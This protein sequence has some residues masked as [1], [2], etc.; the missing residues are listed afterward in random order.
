MEN[1]SIQASEIED[2]LQSYPSSDLYLTFII[3]PK[4]KI[5]DVA[6]KNILSVF[7]KPKLKMQGKS[8]NL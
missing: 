8:P 6:F 3:E 4:D 2:E 5:Y 7:K 1:E